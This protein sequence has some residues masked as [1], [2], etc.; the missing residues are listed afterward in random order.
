[1]LSSILPRFAAFQSITSLSLH[2]LSI[3]HFDD[4]DIRSIFGHLFQ[5]VRR[6]DLEEPH[7]TAR[8]LLRFLCNFCA[9]EDLSISDPEWDR[10]T[11]V[12]QAAEAG[13]TPPL[14]GTLHFLRLHADSA[15]FVSLLAGLPIAF[16]CVS[17]VNCQ[18]PSTPVN[19]L[20]K[21]LAQSLAALT[22]SSW[23][24]G[25]S[26]PPRSPFPTN[27]QAQPIVSRTSILLPV[28]ESRKSDFL[29]ELFQ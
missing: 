11:K 25:V 7:A 28:L 9:L 16:R 5:T 12:P 6:L 18:L 24:N 13:S 2:S 14:H 8:G 4:V 27:R 26:D 3:H 29:W 15:D 17:L 23:F 19:L 1:M 10:E 20:L 21:G 22:V